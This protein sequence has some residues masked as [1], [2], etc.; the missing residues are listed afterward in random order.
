MLKTSAPS[1]S[2]TQ[3]VIPHELAESYHVLE[4]DPAAGVIVLCDHANNAFPPG[5]GTLGLPADQ[6]IRHIAYDIGAA[7]VTR[8]LSETLNAP[9]VMTRYSRLL[10]DPNR[11]DDDPTL[12]MRISDGAVVPGNRILDD[13]ER[14]RR[15]SKYYDPYHA[16]I[17]QVIDGCIA[18]GHVPMLF[19]IHSYTD[20]WRG[21]QRPWHCG[22]LWDE[23]DRLALPLLQALR[24]EGDLLVGDNEPYTGRLKGDCMWQHGTMRGLAHCIIEIRQDLITT[25]EGQA[26]W[27]KRLARILQNLIAEPTFNDRVGRVEFHVSNADI[28]RDET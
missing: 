13:A 15:K 19:S 1:K 6:L 14:E 21:A 10:I 24:D 9:A 8:L 26:S 16:A 2:P 28:D 17:D 7:E 23:D 22:I 27:A 3:V 11:G 25:G 12:I 5:Y 4:G 18:A 20:V